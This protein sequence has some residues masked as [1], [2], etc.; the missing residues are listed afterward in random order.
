MIININNN[1]IYVYIFTYLFIYLCIYLFILF[2]Y[3]FKSSTW[4]KRWCDVIEL[5]YES[6]CKATFVCDLLIIRSLL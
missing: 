6:K 3:L 5:E 1:I 2:I 4:V